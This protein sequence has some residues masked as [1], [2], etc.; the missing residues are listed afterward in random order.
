MEP[1]RHTLSVDFG[2]QYIG[3]ALVRHEDGIANRA[4]YAA[5]V[6]VDA[7]PLSSAVNVR[8]QTRRIRRT[9][10][11]HRRRLRRLAQSLAGIGG[12]DEIV[13][14]CRRRGFSHEPTEPDEA[15]DASAFRV[16]R[17]E[18]FRALRGEV[19]RIVAPADRG[20]IARAL[21]QAS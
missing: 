9:R 1:I 11:T 15:D 5:T 20:T 12:A 2:S 21:C 19:D 17:E 3:L 6:V 13:R 16:S 10:K 7:K 14:F 8:V 18:F 4:V